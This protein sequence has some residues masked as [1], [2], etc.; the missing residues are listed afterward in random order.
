VREATVLGGGQAH[1]VSAPERLP[2]DE[3]FPLADPGQRRL[4]VTLDAALGM[5]PLALLPLAQILGQPA[6]AR[7]AAY[8][9][10]AT[11]PRLFLVNLALLAR[12][13]QTVGKRLVGLRIVQRDGRRASLGRL[14]WRRTSLPGL[15]GASPGFGTLFAVADA[16]M[17]FSRGRMTLH[18]RIAQTIVVDLRRRPECGPTSF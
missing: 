2:R 7:A 13:G 16:L 6:L 18:D 5:S 9:L 12:Y 15:L 11:T 8:Y 14:S 17:I 3:T 1:A 4:A 10:V